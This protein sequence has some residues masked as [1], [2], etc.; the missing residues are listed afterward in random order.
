MTRWLVC[1]KANVTIRFKAA[2]VLFVQFDLKL[3][4][5]RCFQLHV[6]PFYLLPARS[7]QHWRTHQYVKSKIAWLNYHAQTTPDFKCLAE[8][9]R[10]YTVTVKVWILGYK[11]SEHSRST[12][13]DPES[14][15]AVRVRACLHAC[16]RGR[17]EWG[18]QRR[19]NSIHVSLTH[20]SNTQGH[21]KVCIK[22]KHLY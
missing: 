15:T 2:G 20:Q 6:L 1:T 13:R 22:W 5:W 19:E 9:L 3:H 11:S 7:M 14:P 21:S 16:A 4:F 18:C 10:C 12:K 8:L 17:K